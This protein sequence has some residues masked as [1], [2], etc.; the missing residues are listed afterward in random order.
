[1]VVERPTPGIS[2]IDSHF[3]FGADSSAIFDL[4]SDQ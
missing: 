1:L 4:Q 2:S 3:F